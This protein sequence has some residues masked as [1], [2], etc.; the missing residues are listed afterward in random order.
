MKRVTRLGGDVKKKSTAKV[1]RV[2]AYCRVSTDSDAQLE[3]LD[4]QKTH[5]EN[6]I[7]GREDWEFAGLYFDEGISGTKK[8]KRPAV[9]YTHLDVYKRQALEGTEWSVGTV[10]VRTKRTW[11][12]TEKNAL[13]ILRNTADLHGG[14]LVFDLSLIHIFL[15]KP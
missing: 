14:D 2:A 9:S 8:E 4:A 15:Q 3:S 13:S 6:Y 7:N 12:S 10:T 11:T 1:L 5:Y